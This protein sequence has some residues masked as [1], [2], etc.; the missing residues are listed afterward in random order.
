MAARL[1]YD[2]DVSANST[3]DDAVSE[4]YTPIH[5][6]LSEILPVL[7]DSTYYVGANCKSSAFSC[8]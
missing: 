5:R 4:G 3:G 7:E 8:C 6:I 2:V 1:P